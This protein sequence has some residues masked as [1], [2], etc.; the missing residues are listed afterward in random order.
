MVIAAHAQ[1][2]AVAEAFYKARG[3]KGSVAAVAERDFGVTATAVVEMASI[4]ARDSTIPS[5]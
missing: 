3:V 4:L 1:K 5:A 2:I